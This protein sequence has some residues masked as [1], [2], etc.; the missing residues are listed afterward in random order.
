[1]Q[2][3]SRHVTQSLP[4]NEAEKIAWQAIRNYAQ[5]ATYLLS[6]L[7]ILND[8]LAKKLMVDSQIEILI[9]N[10][11]LPHAE[12]QSPDSETKLSVPTKEKSK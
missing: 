8:N 3:S 2:M 5:Q 10:L 7:E 9:W 4:S 12:I 6:F 11:I 1:M